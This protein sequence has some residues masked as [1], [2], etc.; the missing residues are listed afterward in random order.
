MTNRAHIPTLRRTG[1]LDRPEVLY[2]ARKFKRAPYYDFEESF[3]HNPYLEREHG[4]EKAVELYRQMVLSRGDMLARLPELRD[5]TYLACWCKLDE[6]CHVDVLLELL[7]SRSTLDGTA[8]D[9]RVRELIRQHAR[10][11][12]G[13]DARLYDLWDEW[14][15]EFFGGLMVPALVQITD[16][17]QTHCYGRCTTYSGLA[18][19]RHAIKIRKSILDGTLRDLKDGTGDQEGLWRFLTDVLLHEML[20]QFAYEV[21]GQHDGSYHGHGPAFSALANEIGAKLG[22]PPVGRTYRKR[23]TEKKGLPSPSQWPHNVRPHPEYYRGAHVPSSVDDIGALKKSL[24]RAIDKHGRLKV[25]RLVEEVGRE[26]EEREGE[27]ELAKSG[28]KVYSPK[29]RVPSRE[30]VAEEA[31]PG[32]LEAALKDAILGD[33]A[34]ASPVEE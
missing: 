19:I 28:W 34:E 3:W 16:P 27:E 1:E 14:N 30:D 21:T 17:G 31:S 15:E 33:A 25:L 11:Q 26:I 20:H 8:E 4:R 18:G 12:E 32:G 10:G 29:K 23:D 5:Y 2:M 6:L 24:A 7:E 22:L 13:Y 9:R